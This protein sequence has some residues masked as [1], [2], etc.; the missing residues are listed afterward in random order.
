MFRRDSLLGAEICREEEGAPGEPGDRIDRLLTG[1]KYLETACAEMLD[2][3]HVDGRGV[4]RRGRPMTAPSQIKTHG[5][6]ETSCRVNYSTGELC[7]KHALRAPT[8]FDCRLP[9]CVHRDVMRK[10]IAVRQSRA[11]H[12][13]KKGDQS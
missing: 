3:M 5:L 7:C 2:D 6:P 13:R 9:Y 10:R 11:L 1:L 8:K 12:A 4:L